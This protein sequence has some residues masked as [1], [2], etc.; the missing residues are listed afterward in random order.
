MSIVRRRAAFQMGSGVLG[1]VD[2]APV[3]GSQPEGTHDL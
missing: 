1:F 2:I 3:A